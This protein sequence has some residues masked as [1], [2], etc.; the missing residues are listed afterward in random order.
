MLALIEIILKKHLKAFIY[1][2]ERLKC[3]RALDYLIGLKMELNIVYNTNYKISIKE[4]IQYLTM[5]DSNI[6]KRITY[7]LLYIFFKNKLRKYYLNKYNYMDLE[8]K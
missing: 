7:T 1:V 8:N 2:Y 4:Y 6:I 3:K 5:L